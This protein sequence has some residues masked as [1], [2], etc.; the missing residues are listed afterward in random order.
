MDLQ[1]QQ[2]GFGPYKEWKGAISIDCLTPEYDSQKADGLDNWIA[3]ARQ[4]LTA[5]C[6]GKKSL[7]IE[8]LDLSGRQLDTLGLV[9]V[10]VLLSEFQI[11]VSIRCFML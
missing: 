4:I 5:L 8:R 7:E 10:C 6:Y 9:R 2:L 3:E 11:P 1:A